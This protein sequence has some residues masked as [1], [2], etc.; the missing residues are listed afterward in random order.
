MAEPFTE[1]Q[2]TVAVPIVK[3]TTPYTR[4]GDLWARLFAAAAGI[5]LLAGII[6]R[7]LASIKQ[8]RK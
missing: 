4:Y 3:D 7:I 6:G 8:G 2:L 1:T 5:I